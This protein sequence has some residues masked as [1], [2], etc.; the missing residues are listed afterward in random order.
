MYGK[1]FIY[2]PRVFLNV[3]WHCPTIK[4]S[5]FKRQECIFKGYFSSCQRGAEVQS[6]LRK[7]DVLYRRQKN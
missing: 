2:S 4:V 6:V 3:Y 7:N 5:M 1:S